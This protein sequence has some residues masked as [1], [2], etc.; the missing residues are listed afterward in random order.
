MERKEKA[1]KEGKEGHEG[2]GDTWCLFVR[3]LQHVWDTGEI[4][5]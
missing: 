1:V 5:R 4:P 3:R 2:A